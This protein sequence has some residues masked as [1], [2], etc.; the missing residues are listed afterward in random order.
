MHSRRRVAVKAAPTGARSGP[1]A[2]LY[3]E[4]AEATAPRS[5]LARRACRSGL[6]DGFARGSQVCREAPSHLGGVAGFGS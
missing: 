6:I 3:S 5:L 4:P 2:R 1:K